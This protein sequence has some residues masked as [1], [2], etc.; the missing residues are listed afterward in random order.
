VFDYNNNGYDRPITIY[1]LIENI[2]IPIP[3]FAMEEIARMFDEGYDI[4]DIIGFIMAAIGS[5]GDWVLDDA[6]LILADSGHILIEAIIMQ[7]VG[8]PE[9]G[10]IQ[11]FTGIIASSV[12]LILSSSALLA[13]ALTKKKKDEKIESR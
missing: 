1:D 8:N 2:D 9:T 10:D 5:P 6:G 12:A 7:D 13:I 11:T 4:E 3:A